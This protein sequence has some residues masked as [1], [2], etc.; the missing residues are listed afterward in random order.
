[1][2]LDST[3]FYAESGGQIGD[4]G[5]L[6][7]VPAAAGQN[8]AEPAVLQVSDVQKAAGGAL[9]VHSVLVTAGSLHVGQQVSATSHS[10][11]CLFYHLPL[12]SLLLLV[13]FPADSTAL[14]GAPSELLRSADICTVDVVSRDSARVWRTRCTFHSA[15]QRFGLAIVCMTALLQR[16]HTVC[17]Y[18]RAFKRLILYKS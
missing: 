8:G 14:H 11:T 17:V 10:E 7:A 15:L 5:T 9:Y 12:L 3:P 16:S 13:P 4:H 18:P 2:V 1:M 6:T